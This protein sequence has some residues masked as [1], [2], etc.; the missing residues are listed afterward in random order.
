MN[1]LSMWIYFIH[2]IV[3]LKIIHMDV[4]FLVPQNKAEKNKS[5]SSKHWNSSH[6]QPLQK[7]IV[8]LWKWKKMEDHG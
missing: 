4:M 6:C 3:I 1:K 2:L 8:L 7:Q 5:Q